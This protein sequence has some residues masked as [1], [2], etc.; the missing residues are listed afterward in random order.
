MAYYLSEDLILWINAQ[1]A[2]SGQ[3]RSAIVQRALEAARAAAEQ[4]ARMG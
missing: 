3:S 1:A 2:A 4:A